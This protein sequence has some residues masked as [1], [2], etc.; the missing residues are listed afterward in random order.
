MP[1]VIPSEQEVLGYFNECSNWGRWGPEDQRGTLNY[2]TPQ[3]RL[4]AA[5]LVK[6]G[7]SVSCSRSIFHEMAPDVLSPAV[8]LMQSSGEAWAGKKSVA[9][10]T[11]GSSD[12]IGLAFHGFTT[13]H[14][15]SLAHQFW[16]GK[17]YNGFPSDA[18]TTREGATKGSVEQ[19]QDGVLTRGVLLDIPRLKGVKWL[20]P[21]TP[22]FPEDLGEAERACDVRVESGDLLFVRTGWLRMRNEQGPVNPAVAG[23]PG[24]EGGTCVPWVHKRQVAV[25]GSDVPNEVSPSGYKLVMRPIHQVGIVAMGLWL[26]DNANLE[27][28]AAACERHHRWEFMATM[29]PLRIVNGTGSPVNPIATF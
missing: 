29:E 4:Q 24:L 27:D 28:L 17:M 5:G 13:T 18:V 15:D 10:Q 16:D 12:F 22:I 11:Q 6:K 20:E 8:H 26:I 14:L 21:G 3:K 9:G 25:L 19:L 2:I 7:V 1:G 23:R